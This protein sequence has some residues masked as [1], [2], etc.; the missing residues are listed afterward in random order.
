MKT[1]W[2][3]KR[4]KQMSSEKKNSRNRTESEREEDKDERGRLPVSRDVLKKRR[5]TR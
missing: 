2:K 4:R 3:T 5:I 1:I